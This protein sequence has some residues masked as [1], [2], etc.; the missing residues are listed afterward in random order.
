MPMPSSVKALVDKFERDAAYYRSPG[1]NEARTRREFIDPFFEALGWDMSNT[2]GVAVPYRDV[3][4]ED[5]IKISGKNKA[6]DYSFRVGGARR[7]FVEAKKPSVNIEDDV[8]PAFQLRRYAWSSNLPV[9]ILSDFEEFAVYDCRIMPNKDDRATVARVLYIPYTEYEERW[10]EIAEIFSR[11]AVLAG[12]LDSLAESFKTKRGTRTVDAAFLN[13]IESWRDALARDIAVRNPTLSQRNLNLAVQLTIDRIVF[14]RISED[15]GIEP[16]GRMEQ[17]L[18]REGIYQELCRFF[19]QADDRYNSGLFHFQKERDRPELPDDL[20]LTLAIGDEVLSSII[21]HL[22]YPESPYE[23]SVL[24]ADI[25]G[26]VYEQFLGKVIHLSGDRQV[27]VEEKPEVRKAGGVYY[28]PTYVVEY[29]IA[30]TIDP[31][32]NGKSP[33]QVSRLRFL[34]PACGSG[35]FLIALYQ[36]LLDWH[37]S[38][39]VANAPEKLRDKVYQGPRGEWRLTADERKSILLHNIYGVDI[40]AQAVETTKL[41]LL[42]KVL[43]GESASSLWTQLELIHKRALPDLGN[44][45]KC[46]NSL[47]ASDYYSIQQLSFL[48]DELRVTVQSVWVR[49]I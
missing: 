33:L 46:G 26:Q 7:F 5:A 8:R 41:S 29:I 6:P 32:L 4:Y 18:A 14:L 28:T 1:Y 23:F 11:D 45:I 13:E 30:K 17:L 36:R 25:L 2:Q 15:R 44:N 12:S 10:D 21:S 39:Y 22:Y 31:L 27:K 24:P 16:Y 20:T 19:R 38:Y 49:S 42:L 47:I 3:I 40:D 48:D 43:E 34:D 35:S 9:S 37:L